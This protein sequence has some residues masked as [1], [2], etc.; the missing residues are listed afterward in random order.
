MVHKHATKNWN[1]KAEKV[2]CRA[3]ETKTAVRP[4]GENQGAEKEKVVEDTVVVNPSY[5]AEEAR[6]PQKSGMAKQ[7]NK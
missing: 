4:M 2:C 5:H 7:N 3:R 6:D 1:V